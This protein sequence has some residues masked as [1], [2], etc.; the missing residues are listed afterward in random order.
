MPVRRRAS[1]STRAAG[2]ADPCDL[3]PE[4]KPSASSV[5]RIIHDMRIAG[6]DG[7]P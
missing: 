5:T 3:M 4:D 1:L 6:A 7:D 2:D